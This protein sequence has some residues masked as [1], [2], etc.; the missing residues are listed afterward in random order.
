L[1]WSNYAGTPQEQPSFNL[2]HSLSLSHVNQCSTSFP[3]SPF[4]QIIKLFNGSNVIE[5]LH[6]TVEN[7]S[8]NLYHVSKS[9]P[10]ISQQIIPK[11]HFSPLI[12]YHIY[13]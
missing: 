3:H 8:H 6:P 5:S 12:H 9:H 2:N 7:K 1:F 10:V 11:Q 4:D 13:S